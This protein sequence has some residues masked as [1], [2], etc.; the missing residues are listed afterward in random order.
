M[1]RFTIVLHFQSNL[2]H[3]DSHTWRLVWQYCH[4]K[5]TTYST[6]RGAIRSCIFSSNGPATTSYGHAQNR[7]TMLVTSEIRLIHFTQRFHLGVRTGGLG[8]RGDGMEDREPVS[9]F[10]MYYCLFTLFCAHW[11]STRHKHCQHWFYPLHIQVH[12]PSLPKP[13]KHWNSTLR[14]SCAT[15][16][17]PLLPM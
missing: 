9:T 13:L 2:N 8:L 15:L 16:V 10:D 12:Y 3:I 4:I 14:I 17:C 1:C 6:L 7:W 11:I 5:L